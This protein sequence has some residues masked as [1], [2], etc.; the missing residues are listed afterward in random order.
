[1]SRSFSN[2]D[3]E[4]DKPIVTSSSSLAMRLLVTSTLTAGVATFFNK[5]IV[6]EQLCIAA[7]SLYAVLSSYGCRVGSSLGKNVGSVGVQ[8]S[9]EEKK[10]YFGVLGMIGLSGTVGFITAHPCSTLSN[11]RFANETLYKTLTSQ[12][13][14]QLPNTYRIATGVSLF[15]EFFG[16]C[17]YASSLKAVEYLHVTQNIPKIAAY[18]AVFS[19]SMPLLVGV[20]TA[21]SAV[22]NEII[23]RTHLSDNKLVSP[24]SFSTFHELWK[25]KGFAL[26]TKA[27][28]KSAKKIISIFSIIEGV[29]MASQQLGSHS[30]ASDSLKTHDADVQP[31]RKLNK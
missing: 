17:W 1:M 29:R 13:L 15:S 10:Q 23:S 14:K 24:N 12:L 26:F 31:A 7:P 21:T 4:K 19:F 5:Q 18:T 11:T 2:P 30:A 27:S 8:Y 28:T 9:N 3:K 16:V 20:S 22:S 6:K 25:N